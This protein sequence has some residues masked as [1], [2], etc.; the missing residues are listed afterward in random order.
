[1]LGSAQ[2]LPGLPGVNKAQLLKE[3][4]AAETTILVKEAFRPNKKRVASSIV[5]AKDPNLEQ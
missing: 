2:A 3:L 4:E 5:G 1:M